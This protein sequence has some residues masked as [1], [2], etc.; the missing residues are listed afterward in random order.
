MR[1]IFGNF[2]NTLRKYKISSF[3]NIAGMAVAFA[4][5][6]VILSQVSY[7]FGYNK[8]LKDCDKLFVITTPSSYDSG[9]FSAW[10]CR[11]FGEKVISGTPMVESGGVMDIHNYPDN[12]LCWTRRHTI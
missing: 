4:A 8:K 10:L 2:I 7:N 11:P 5:F 1:Y 12:N 9:K 3:L 6:Y